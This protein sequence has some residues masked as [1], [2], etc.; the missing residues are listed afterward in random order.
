MKTRILILLAILL[1]GSSTSTR[2]QTV[3]KVSF[4]NGIVYVD[5]NR[6]APK[7]LPATLDARSL[8]GNLNFWSDE[9]AL[10]QIRDHVYQVVD[11][12]LLEVT[13][14][15]QEPGRVM[16]Y[17]ANEDKEFPVRVLRSNKAGVLTERSN[18]QYSFYVKALQSQAAELDSIRVVFEKTTPENA[19]IM[20]RMVAEVESAARIAE[21][22]PQAQY[23]AYLHEVQD[24][25]RELYEEL[26]REH[27]L[28]AESRRLALRMA[29]AR[30]TAES[31]RLRNELHSKLN[32][33]FDLKQR[34]RQ[35]EIEQLSAQLKD[36]QERLQAR[37]KQRE[38]LIK[39]RIEELTDGR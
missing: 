26:R 23:Q 5:G 3:H 13:V 16:V 33:I 12:K 35:R 18:D 7:D 10:L 14:D 36:L 28:E 1:L 9:D 15:E 39:R 24:N 4:E 11:G 37:E 27:A 2:A 29:A 8:R 20:R 17:F 31:E 34:N 19:G 6:L 25:D 32:T 30:S 22:L 21:V 38:A